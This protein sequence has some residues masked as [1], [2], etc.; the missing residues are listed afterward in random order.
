MRSR[1]SIQSGEIVGIGGPCRCRPRSGWTARTAAAVRGTPVAVVSDE[2]ELEV[3]D[4]RVQRPSVT[5]DHPGP[6]P[7]SCGVIGSTAQ[8]VL[9]RL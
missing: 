1:C 3:P 8:E 6:K 9:H 4:V 2:L 5:D 7:R